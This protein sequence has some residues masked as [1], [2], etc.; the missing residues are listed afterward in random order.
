YLDLKFSLQSVD[1]HLKMKFTHSPKNRLT[2]F[3]IRRNLQSRIL[4]YQLR[5][6]HT[7]FINI[8]LSLRLNRITNNRFRE[9]HRL[10]NNLVL[11]IT[12]RIACLDIFKANNRSD[13]TRD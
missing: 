1:N 8:S 9:L 12:K 13:I 3:L 5:D 2:S 4:F 10:K 11:F 6:S 7:H